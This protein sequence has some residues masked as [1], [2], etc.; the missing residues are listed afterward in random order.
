MSYLDKNIEK[1]KFDIYKWLNFGV[2]LNSKMIHIK[3]K[4]KNT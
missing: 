2:L 1:K 4:C 3:I